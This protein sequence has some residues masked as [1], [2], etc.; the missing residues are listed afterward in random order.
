MTLEPA[1]PRRSSSN[2]IGHEADYGWVT[3]QLYHL[4][5]ANGGLWGCVTPRRRSPRRRTAAAMLL[6]PAIDMGN[7]ATATCVR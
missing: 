1:G 7:S 5:A 6:A 4:R 3:G 2:R